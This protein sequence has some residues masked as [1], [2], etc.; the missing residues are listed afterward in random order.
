MYVWT[1]VSSVGSFPFLPAS[2]AGPVCS[3]RACPTTATS[4]TS[5]APS[6]RPR[7]GGQRSPRGGSERRKRGEKY[8][9]SPRRRKLFLLLPQSHAL[10]LV[11]VELGNTVVVTTVQSLQRA[12]SFFCNYK[13]QIA[14]QSNLHYCGRLGCHGVYS[15]FSGGILVLTPYLLEAVHAKSLPIFIQVSCTEWEWE[16]ESKK[17]NGSG[18]KNCGFLPAAKTSGHRKTQRDKVC[19]TH[20]HTQIALRLL[21][22]VLKHNLRWVTPELQDLSLLCQC[23]NFQNLFLFFFFFR[24]LMETKE[25][26]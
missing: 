1:Y 12:E 20:T 14:Y 11:T 7:T 22:R 3:A 24:T 26:E 23:Y 2:A 21:F 9:S 18:L 25:H 13:F 15:Y 6:T 8:H 4:A 16:A 17:R 19:P 5:S 10:Y